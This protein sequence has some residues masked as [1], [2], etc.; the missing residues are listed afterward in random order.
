MFLQQVHLPQKCPSVLALVMKYT[1]RMANVEDKSICDLDC[2]I[3]WLF[4]LAF[5]CQSLLI[6]ESCIIIQNL[7]NQ[8]L[9]MLFLH[10]VH[11]QWL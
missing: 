6:F 7:L 5:T 11:T 10:V 4:T 3:S 2:E 9:M 8:H 1:I